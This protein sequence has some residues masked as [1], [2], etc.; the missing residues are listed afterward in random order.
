M[1][2]LILL[3]RRVTFDVLYAQCKKEMSI[4]LVLQLISDIPEAGSNHQRVPAGRALTREP[5][6][7]SPD[8]KERTRQQEQS[9][10]EVI[11]STP[12]QSSVMFVMR[13]SL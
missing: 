13:K 2:F 8:H 11:W 12:C 7:S 9:R 4:L 5:V 6:Q 3:F 10:N 1:L